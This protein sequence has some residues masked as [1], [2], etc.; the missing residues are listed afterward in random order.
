MLG[1]GKVRVAADGMAEFRIRD[2]KHLLQYVIPLFDQHRL[3]TSKYYHYDL[4]KR[5]LLIA[6]NPAIT[7]LQKHS[8]L[9]ELSFQSAK[10]N[11]MR[12]ADYISPV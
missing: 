5:A 12:P 3:L 10:V 7:T 2:T 9:T 6:T 11:A 4:F 1:V 8:L